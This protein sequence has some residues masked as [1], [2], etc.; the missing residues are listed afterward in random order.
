M[1][2]HLYWQSSCNRPLAHRY[3]QSSSNGPLAH[4]YWQ[5]SCNG[6]LARCYCGGQSQR[7]TDVRVPVATVGASSNHVR[8]T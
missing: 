1:I 7:E 8:A 4:H 5:S 3:W 6:S 2:A